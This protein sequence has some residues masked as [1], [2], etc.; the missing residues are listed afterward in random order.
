MQQYIQ[1]AAH[2]DRVRS[3]Q[4]HKDSPTSANPARDAEKAPDELQHPF[5]IKLLNETHNKGHT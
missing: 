1:E 2:R 5:M 4:R 3:I